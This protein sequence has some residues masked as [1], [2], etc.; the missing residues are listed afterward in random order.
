MRKYPRMFDMSKMLK[1]KKKKKVPKKELTKEQ[2]QIQGKKE[3]QG[4]L[5]GLG[6]KSEHGNN[7]L[8]KDIYQDRRTGCH[9]TNQPSWPSGKRK[10]GTN[11]Q[12]IHQMANRTA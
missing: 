5:Q 1:K 2:A 10:A 4:W 11:R 12:S 8:S 9:K 6:V 3:Q 7:I